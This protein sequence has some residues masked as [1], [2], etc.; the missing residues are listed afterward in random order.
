MLRRT[1]WVSLAAAL[2][3]WNKLVS[4]QTTFRGA[5]RRGADS[6]CSSGFSECT[7]RTEHPGGGGLNNF[8]GDNN[9]L[10]FGA[11]GSVHS[12][13]ARA[14]SWEHGFLPIYVLV[15]S[16]CGGGERGEGYYQSTLGGHTCSTVLSTLSRAVSCFPKRLLGKVEEGGVGVRASARQHKLGAVY[17]I[18]LY[19]FLDL[20]QDLKHS[21]KSPLG[22]ACLSREHERGETRSE[23]GGWRGC[24]WCFSLVRVTH[25]DR[26]WVS[27]DG[28]NVSTVYLSRGQPKDTSPFVA[29]GVCPE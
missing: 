20:G 11:R 4:F 16:A 5:A 27:W 12:R 19:S 23:T 13:A 15:F 29:R 22:E 21:R 7:R 28:I 26:T 14:I 9:R 1:S 8:E 6:A 10:V 24:S 3:G 18:S 25:R 2:H 17:L